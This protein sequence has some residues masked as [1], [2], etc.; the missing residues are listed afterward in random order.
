MTQKLDIY[1]KFEGFEP[2]QSLIKHK[3]PFVLTKCDS[4]YFLA[5]Q[6]EFIQANIPPQLHVYCNLPKFTR[7][8]K[9]GGFKVIMGRHTYKQT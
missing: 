9:L 6:N 1:N 2:Q 8:I 3:V 4:T 7:Q 5:R